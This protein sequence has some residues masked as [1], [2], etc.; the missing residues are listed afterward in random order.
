MHDMQRSAIPFFLCLSQDTVSC[1]HTVFFT[2][3]CLCRGLLCNVETEASFSKLGFEI[4]GTLT[5]TAD[6]NF[7]VP[8]AEIEVEGCVEFTFGCPSKICKRESIR[9]RVSISLAEVCV[10]A[11]VKVL[12]CQLAEFDECEQAP[13]DAT[14]PNLDTLGAIALGKCPARHRFLKVCASTAYHLA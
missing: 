4:G 7:F 14:G 13:I 11:G 1:S 6:P 5:A 9:N 3:K 2:P 10:A 8:T 12:E